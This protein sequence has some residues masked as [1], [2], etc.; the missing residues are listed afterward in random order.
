MWLKHHNP[1][2]DWKG[3]TIRFNHCRSC[4]KEEIGTNPEDDTNS[5]LE[6]GERLL[7]VHIGLEELNIRTKTTYS[8][9]IASPRKD[10]RMIEEILPKH[11]HPYRD[12]F[13]KQ[14]FDKLPPRHP[15][16]HAI[17]LVKGAKALDCKIY[18]SPKRNRLSS[19]S[20]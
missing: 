15:W 7:A 8:T 17:E 16:D 2:I 5:L 13:K 11:C 19:R 18:R 14:M 9:E 20:F 1:E 3:K 10:T 6:E 12:V 4:Y